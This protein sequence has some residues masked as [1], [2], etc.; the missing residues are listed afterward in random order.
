MNREDSDLWAGDTEPWP[1]P[2]P[3][4]PRG[5]LLAAI[6]LGTDIVASV[7]RLPS[8]RSPLHRRLE[9]VRRATVRVQVC[10]RRPRVAA[11]FGPD[12][13]V[14]ALSALAESGRSLAESLE[15]SARHFRATA[16]A[17]RDALSSVY[18]ALGLHWTAIANACSDGTDEALIG[19]EVVTERTYAA[20]LSFSPGLALAEKYWPFYTHSAHDDEERGRGRLYELLVDR[21]VEV[22]RPRP[23]PGAELRAQAEER[24]LRVADVKREVAQRSLYAVGGRLWRHGRDVVLLGIRKA[25]AELEEAHAHR[26]RAEKTSGV[27][28]SLLADEPAD[29]LDAISAAQ[30]A[31]QALADL[32][33]TASPAQ[34]DAMRAMQTAVPSLPELAGADDPDADDSTLLR[35]HAAEQLGNKEATLRVQLRRLR[36]KAS[37]KS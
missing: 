9:D 32:L 27:G 18:E 15:H 17:L 30:E 13:E 34:A 5:A 25:E 33:A 16:D 20:A 36:T 14:A 37:D 12:V 2:Q 23:R 4:S 31:Q 10:V 3:L 29:P 21:M 1:P 35:R 7:D 22:W 11:A 8:K 28:P 19:L 6:R 26:T 24:G